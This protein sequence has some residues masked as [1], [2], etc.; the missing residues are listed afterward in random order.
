MYHFITT[1]KLNELI[2]QQPII[3]EQPSL[4]LIGDLRKILGC[5]IYQAK[6]LMQRSNTIQEAINLNHSIIMEM[7]KSN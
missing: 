3:N 2:Q 5:G 4:S 6:L 7:H 1:K